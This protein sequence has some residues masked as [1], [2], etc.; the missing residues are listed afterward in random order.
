MSGE[1][2]YQKDHPDMREGKEVKITRSIKREL[3][4]RFSGSP[5]SRSCFSFSQEGFPFS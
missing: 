5:V 1:S 3:P 4:D 2:G